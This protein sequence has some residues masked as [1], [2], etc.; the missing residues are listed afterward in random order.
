MPAIGHTVE[1]DGP[2]DLE[3]RGREY[4]LEVFQ[5]LRGGCFPHPQ[6]ATLMLEIR[7]HQFLNPARVTP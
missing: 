7:P 3:D 4:V 2:P 1:T 5:H 6:R